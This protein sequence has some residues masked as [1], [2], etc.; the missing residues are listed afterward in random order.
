LL[1]LA[2]YNNKRSLGHLFSRFESLPVATAKVWGI[3][4]GCRLEGGDLL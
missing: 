3:D 4:R 1:A 2:I